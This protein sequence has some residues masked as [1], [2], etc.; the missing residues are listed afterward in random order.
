MRRRAQYTGDGWTI[1]TFLRDVTERKIAENRI[2]CLNRVHAMLSGINTLIVHERDRKS[3]MKKACRIAVEDGGLR[4]SMMALIDRATSKFMP[5]GLASKDKRLRS[6]VRSALEACEGV[7]TS[8]V[9]QAIREKRA[10]VSNDSQRDPKVAFAKLHVVFGVRSMAI[11]P[12]IIANEV[13]GVLSLY[14]DECQ[15]FHE[16]E[17][18][19][20][21][22]LTNDVAFAVDHIEK[23]ERLEYLASYDVV[24]GLAN[25]SLF[26]D[27]VAQLL[28]R[29]E[30]NGLVHALLL[31]DLHAFRNVNDGLGRTV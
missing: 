24:T 16:E 22:E 31:I 21:T 19:L 17:V 18:K 29:L 2:A 9:K 27:R 5:V 28:R 20:L 6:A 7:P 23:Q 4:L 30:G 3:L 11:F 1:V 14:A 25:R 8:M 12:L 26:M 13:I 10:V 15:F